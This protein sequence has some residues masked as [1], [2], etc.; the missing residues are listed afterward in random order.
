MAEQDEELDD[1]ERVIRLIEIALTIGRHILHI[2]WLFFGI[3]VAVAAYNF[4]TSNIVW[5]II[6]SLFALGSFIFIAQIYEHRS[7]HR[8]HRLAR[9][10]EM[11]PEYKEAASA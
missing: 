2:A 10:T 9:L 11:R 6:S 8:A 4:A 3:S 5:G 1:I 7:R